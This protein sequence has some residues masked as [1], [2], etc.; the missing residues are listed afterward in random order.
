MFFTNAMETKTVLHYCYRDEEWISLFYGDKEYFSQLG[1]RRGM[2]LDTAMDTRNGSHYCYVDK[3]WLTLLLWRR[4]MAFTIALETRNLFPY[5]S[6]EQ[7]SVL[8][9]LWSQM[10]RRL[11]A[12]E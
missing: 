7:T 12:I 1:W 10:F 2:D 3:E 11:P 8:L 5:R 9:L 4:G 6:G